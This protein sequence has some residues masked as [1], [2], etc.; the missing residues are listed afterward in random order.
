MN[1]DQR[2]VPLVARGTGTTYTLDI[3]A[4]RG[5]VLPG[6]YLLFALDARGAPSVGHWITIA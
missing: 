6:P 2:R 5:V 1:D 3:P 4:D